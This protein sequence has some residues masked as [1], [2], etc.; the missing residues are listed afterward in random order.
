MSMKS[1]RLNPND[2][3]SDMPVSV[4]SMIQRDEFPYGVRIHLTGD[5]LDKMQT[6]YDTFEDKALIHVH[7]MARVVG[8]SE[9][10]ENGKTRRTVTLQFEDMCIESE[11][12]ENVEEE[13]HEPMSERRKRLYDRDDQS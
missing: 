5:E 4:G 9:S 1:L 12:A 2:L 13:Q 8:K 7:G 10:T 3:M 11:D 6:P